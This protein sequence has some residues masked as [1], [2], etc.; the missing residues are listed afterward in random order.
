M[1][2]AMVLWRF[3]INVAED[4]EK[5]NGCGFPKPED[6]NPPIGVM[7]PIRGQD[8]LIEIRAANR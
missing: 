2:V 1:F 3:D 7:G 8:V 6:R 5:T 4:D